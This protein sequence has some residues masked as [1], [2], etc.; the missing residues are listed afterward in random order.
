[1]KANI[2]AAIYATDPYGSWSIPSYFCST[3]NCTWEGYSSLGVCSRC[4]DLTSKLTK[5]CVPRP[6]ID[7]PGVT[8]CDVSL[9][10]GF[11]LGGVGGSRYN[12][13]AMNTSFQP[14]VYTNYTTPIAVVQSIT[15]YDTFFV[16]S[17]TPINASECALVPCVLKYTNSATNSS[18]ALKAGGYNGI[19]FV[20]YADT[21]W[22]SYTFDSNQQSP[23]NGPTINVPL[24]TSRNDPTKFSMDQG[25][26]L[27]LKYYTNALLNGFVRGDITENLSFLS[28][29]RTQ[30]VTASPQ[31]AM[32][33]I[34]Q[35]CSG[36]DVFGNP[37]S[38]WAACAMTFLAGGMTKTIRDN[39]FDLTTNS[40][41]GDTYV[42]QQV[43]TVSWIW[44]I[45]AVGLWLLSTT[46]LIGTAWKTRRTRVK[47]WRGNPLALVFLGLGRK[48]L[49]EVKQHGLTEDGLVKKAEALKVQLRFTDRQAE[50]VHA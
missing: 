30:N 38:D 35:P 6:G 12:L 28:D 26:Y 4:S 7:P 11:N 44:I 21:I 37:V 24:N 39:S 16:N 42:G 49:E 23:L 14:L 40:A 43:V 13:M 15:A 32:Q 29:N 33:A 45:P 9:P 3:G 17:T 18:A 41:I 48:E 8:G 5:N 47:I 20:E 22:D 27:G 46:T 50:L 19:F 1:M 25:T 34:Y 10:N 36:F 31:D 2:W